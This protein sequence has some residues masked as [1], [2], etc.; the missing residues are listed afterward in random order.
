[1]ELFKYLP[2]SVLLLLLPAGIA[3]RVIYT[4]K[5]HREVSIKKVILE[6]ATIF[7]SIATVLYLAYKYIN[8]S[9]F[10]GIY[11]VIIILLPFVAGGYIFSVFSKKN[12][13]R[14]LASIISIKSSLFITYISLYAWSCF[15]T[16]SKPYTWLVEPLITV[17]I[18]FGFRKLF[19]GKNIA[20]WLLFSL[21]ITKTVF[22]S[23]DSGTNHILF[24]SST[25]LL[26]GIPILALVLASIDEITL[27]YLSTFMSH[28]IKIKPQ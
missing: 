12:E 3:W 23:L 26:I 27:N 14:L 19:F 28:Q 13:V 20:A 5:N 21:D 16:L 4:H 9:I 17:L 8:G 24:L 11:F 15:L 2:E 10:L 1:M 6:L 18:I 25:T 22:V 7:L